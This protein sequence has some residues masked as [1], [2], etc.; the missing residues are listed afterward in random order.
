M[1]FEI[2]PAH[3]DIF[4]AVES[5]TDNL[6][7]S[8]VAGSGKTSSIIESIK[9]MPP[10]LSILFLAFS[11]RIVEE[12]VPR[13][14]AVNE[15]AVVMTLNAMGHRAI[16]THLR[17]MGIVSYVEPDKMRRIAR[18]LLT[19]REMRSYGAA[20][21]KLCQLGKVNGI[22]PN[23]LD[24]FLPEGLMPDRMAIWEAIADHHDLEIG[25]K[26]DMADVLSAA[27]RLLRA[28]CEK[29][30]QIDFDD[31]LLLT[32]GM[33]A[34]MQRFD[35]V[36][37]DECQ[38][39][40]PLQ[41]ALV[42]R[43]SA[44]GGRLIAVGDPHQAIYAFRGADSTSMD[45]LRTTFDCKELPLHV[46][47]RCP[48]AVVRVAQRYVDHIQAHA[49][50]PEGTVIEQ[51]VSID[52]VEMLPGD[53]VICR[54]N[55]PVVKAAYSMLRRGIPCIVLGRD[56]GKGLQ[57]LVR[58]LNA[59]SL[60]DMDTRLERWEKTETSKAIEKG[61]VAKQGAIKDKAET[62]RVFIDVSD[63]LNDLVQRIDGMFA[64]ASPDNVVTCCSI[65]K[66]KGLEA[67]RVFIVNFHKMPSKYAKQDWQKQQEENLIYVAVTRAKKH[68]QMV[69][70]GDGR[71]KTSAPK[72]VMTE[73]APVPSEP[74][75]MVPVYGQTFQVKDRLNK[76]LG[77]RWN[78][79]K[80]L[81]F[82]PKN[83]LEET[84]R[85]VS[86]NNG[87]QMRFHRGGDR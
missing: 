25:E 49:G 3:A 4:A 18:D 47:Y 85:I 52:G 82:V 39:L 35:R 57:A 9:R 55:A 23:G 54:Y 5:G 74:D 21:V 64:D 24:G 72:P 26:V 22:L 60:T 42:S 43:A 61:N 68:L 71:D 8:A 20:A 75:E 16:I 79:E 83:R 86:G 30:D 27:S 7:I 29:L 77:A 62:L 19:E 15:S 36:L 59:S 56:I 33:G 32:Y 17:G 46:S 10:D 31:Q 69:T 66:S 70:V 11:K 81:W 51:A 41:H 1:A 13:V 6:M 87:R 34:P 12:L 38:D 84:N 73:G 28:S 80:K 40:S 2:T 37:A 67:D 44:A 78:Q 48:Q 63:D 65:H 45:T 50:A 14:R 58:K 76:E 53:M